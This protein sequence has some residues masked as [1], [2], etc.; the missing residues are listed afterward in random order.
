MAGI[1][2]EVQKAGSSTMV[3][4]MKGIIGK[5]QK[6]GWHLIYL[7]AQSTQSTKNALSSATSLISHASKILLE[8]LRQWFQYF[9]KT[10]ITEKQFS[11]TSGKGTG[12]RKWL[13]GRGAMASFHWIISKILILSSTMLYGKCYGIGCS[14]ASYMADEKKYMMEWLV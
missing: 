8:I 1:L 3:K 9:I 12:F 4:V 13:S 11:V 14:T 5:L 2:S 10:E 6:I 7:F